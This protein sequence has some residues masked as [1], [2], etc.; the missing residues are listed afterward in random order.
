MPPHQ[1]QRRK[2]RG[3]RCNGGLRSQYRL[4]HRAAS[5]RRDL[6]LNTHRQDDGGEGSA[7]GP[8]APG[9]GW[10]DCDY[11]IRHTTAARPLPLP[12]LRGG[13]PRLRLCE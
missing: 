6:E 5:P 10:A 7:A 8:Y 9:V 13:R 12:L 2:A 3:A 1:L 11:D 4:L